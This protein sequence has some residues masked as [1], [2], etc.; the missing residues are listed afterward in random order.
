M[1][2]SRLS[3]ILVAVAII[4]IQ[5]FADDGMWMPQQIPALGDEL[6]AKGL[7]LDPASFADLTGFP[8]GAIVETNGCSATFVSPNGLIVT[9]HHC[10]HGAL[11][12]N[13]TPERDLI[14]N[15][16]LAKSR[17]DEPQASPNARVYV[18]TK[19]EDVTGRVSGKLKKGIRDADRAKTI[20]QRK[21][22]LVKECEA[23]GVRCEVS[24]YFGG[25]MFLRLTQM[26]IRD[27]RL[28]YA[29]ALGVGNF[30]DEDDNW[31]WP[32]HTG[33]FG[34]LRAYVGPDGRTADFAKE[35]VPFQPR[36]WLKVSTRDLDEGDLA[37][38]AGFPGRTS[39]L[40]TAEEVRDAQEWALPTANRYRRELLTILRN[41]GKRGR[42]VEIANATRVSGL[43]NY[44]KKNEG[45]LEAFHR[46]GL[47]DRKVAEERLL[48]AYVQG[49]PEL[50]KRYDPA[51]GEFGRLL[52][53]G[54]A[55]RD[56][57]NVFDWLDTA[58]PML[59][60]ARMLYKL[61]HERAK[62]SDADRSEGFQ[63]RDWQQ[64]K[65]GMQR[66]QRTI[67]PATDRAGL[68]FIL[69]EAAKLPGGQR[70]PAIDAA[71][72]S[73]GASTAEAQIDAFLDSLY[74]GTK[75]ADLDVRTAMFP[76]STAALE[77]RGD[78][79][80]EFAA[81]LYPLAVELENR[82][83][84]VRGARFRLQP[85]MIAAMRAMKGGRLAP[86][87]NGT[88]RVGFGEVKGYEP[89]DGVIYLP[90]TTIDGVLAKDTG[91]R[92]FDSPA[93]LLDLAR[94]KQFGTY[95]DPDLGTLPVAYVT[96][97][98]VTN[99]SS[100]SSSLNAW[101]EII[102]LAFDM[103]WEGVAADWVV[104][105][106]YVRTVNVDSRYMLWVMDAVDGAHDVLREMG[107]EPQF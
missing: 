67:D 64:R 42:A 57:N 97:N 105:E 13:S 31:M 84:E 76:E 79:M 106:K 19:I 59:A 100:G 27:V 101:G 80:I 50:A 91:K 2:L 56:R 69:L 45:V 9:N 54:R 15:G 77:K 43:E 44:L 48:E 86:D 46:D 23:P 49:N 26:E 52:A 35:N 17:A 29:P 82:A 95:A 34:F 61:S 102:G 11:Q 62:K 33:D 12:Y 38:L 89:R 39:R 51:A 94:K 98:N 60:Q 36:H 58:S 71:M 104:N 22:A 8:M 55:M 10:V 1:K 68:R 16:F 78:T 72:A 28:V 37:L 41:E 85:E 81:K 83:L 103:N 47:L 30:G 3:S 7:Q 20:D 96:T 70:I 5:S 21:K 32:R 65:N 66:T 40:V 4:A 88:L 107:I 74:G 93:R 63:E 87:A 25:G 6:K 73:T 24:T 90:Q 53:Q 99:G 18:T 92:P 14:E 75:I